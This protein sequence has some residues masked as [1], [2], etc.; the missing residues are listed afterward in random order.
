[1]F[2]VPLSP[3]A[4]VAVCSP[5]GLT[6]LRT[7]HQCLTERRPCQRIKHLSTHKDEIL[8]VRP[9]A[10]VPCFSGATRLNRRKTGAGGS[11]HF[12]ALVFGHYNSARVSQDLEHLDDG[13]LTCPCGLS[14]VELLGCL[15]AVPRPVAA[16]APGSARPVWVAMAHISCVRVE[17]MG[18]IVRTG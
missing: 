6:A 7:Q 3:S 16:T 10:A 4:P 2:L 18:L 9:S 5:R 15:R 8:K 12:R 17:I 11:A 13:A 1:V 14:A